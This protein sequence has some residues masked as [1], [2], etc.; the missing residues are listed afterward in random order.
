LQDYPDISKLIFTFNVE[1]ETGKS[2]EQPLDLRIAATIALIVR[3]FLKDISK[4]V[5]YIC[6]SSDRKEHIRKRKFDMWFKKHDDG[7]IIKVDHTAIVG[8]DKLLNSLLIHKDNPL[9]NRFLEL[10]YKL[11]RDAERK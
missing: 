4:A 6:G 7:L 8:E 9:K 1:V 11:N 3:K 10:F 2:K 5:I